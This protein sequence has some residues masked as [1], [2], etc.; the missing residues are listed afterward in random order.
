M[1]I[2][3]KFVNEVLEENEQ[4]ES[5]QESRGRMDELY[6]VL[7]D[8]WLREGVYAKIKETNAK[9]ELNGKKV[10][11]L[12]VIQKER[13]CGVKVIEELPTTYVVVGKSGARCNTTKAMVDQVFRVGKCK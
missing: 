7:M 8:C 4:K 6:M 2:A 11:I 10:R 3:S 5:E 13:K 1:H 9:N 12:N